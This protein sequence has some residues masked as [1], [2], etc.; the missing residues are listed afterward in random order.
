[1]SRVN[2]NVMSNAELKQYFLKHRGNQISFQAY[3][4]RINQRPL[5]IIDFDE[6]VQAA[7]RQKLA[8]ARIR[9][10]N[11]VGLVAFVLTVLEPG[12]FSMKIGGAIVL[13]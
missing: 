10:S 2:Y 12:V 5:R 9:L 7:I 6:K 1:M 3:L 11:F 4:D 13:S 8:V